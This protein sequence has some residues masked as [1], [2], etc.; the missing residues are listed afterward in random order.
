MIVHVGIIHSTI[1]RFKALYLKV[2]FVIKCIYHI[3]TRQGSLQCKCDMYNGICMRFFFFFFFFSSVYFWTKSHSMAPIGWS[4]L[5]LMRPTKSRQRVSMRVL[6]M[7]IQHDGSSMGPCQGPRLGSC[8]TTLHKSLSYRERLNRTIDFDCSVIKAP[9][10]VCIKLILCT[11]KALGLYSLSLL[12]CWE[13]ARMGLTGHFFTAPAMG[14][15]STLIMELPW[16]LSKPNGQWPYIWTCAVLVAVLVSPVR[17]Q[18]SVFH[19]PGPD[20]RLALPLD[21]RITS[22]SCVLKQV[23]IMDLWNLILRPSL[24][25]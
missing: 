1:I 9:T 24:G 10:R 3:S 5:G 2:N 19:G 14:L 11:A 6:V 15:A 8:I 20:P 18:P 22:S 17:T 16:E 12:Y 4:D 23:W 7:I 21:S 13:I 25:D